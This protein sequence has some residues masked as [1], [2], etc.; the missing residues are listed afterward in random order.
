MSAQIITVAQHKGGAGKTTLAAHLAVSWAEAGRRVALL[1]TDPQASL[2]TWH[3]QRQSALGRRTQPLAYAAATGWRVHS[4]LDR[5]GRISELVLVDTP[6]S[7]APEARQ[8]LRSSSAVIVPVQPSPLDLWAT[9]TILDEIRRERSRPLIVLTRVPARARLTADVV[10]EIARL[11][12]PIAGARLG[13]RTAFAATL[14]VGASVADWTMQDEQWCVD[15]A[16]EIRELSQ[17]VLD[18]AG[19]YSTDRYASAG[20]W[21]SAGR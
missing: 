2:G 3:R 7:A 11:Q 19:L 14:A 13:N 9:R 5:L 20:A 4:E 8:S 18:F 21:V 16:R 1:D 15:A 17:E 12:S 6:P 10:A